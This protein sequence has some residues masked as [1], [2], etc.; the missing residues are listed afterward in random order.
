MYFVTIATIITIAT[1][2]TI[3]TIA[4][5]LI[6]YKY[7]NNLIVWMFPLQVIRN[8]SSTFHNGST[9]R[10]TIRFIILYVS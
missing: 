10:T 6:M 1:T 8:L 2:V 7:S 4:T 5:V 3:V 9:H